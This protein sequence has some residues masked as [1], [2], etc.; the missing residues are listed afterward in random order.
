[1]IFEYILITIL[2]TLT[3][4]I[5]NRFRQSEFFPYFTG[6]LKENEKDK[7]WSS[8]RFAFILTI[9]ISNI[10][11]WYTYVIISILEHRF[12]EVP[13]AIVFLY[14]LANGIAGASKVFQKIPEQRY[15]GRFNR[16]KAE[17]EEDI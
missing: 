17:D 9:L 1:M 12:V 13:E 5:L 16:V 2:V 6:M 4:W 15:S 10:L 11:V 7:R 3:L 14:G 8:Q